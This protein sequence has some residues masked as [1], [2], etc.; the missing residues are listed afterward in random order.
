MFN[1]NISL[2]TTLV[3]FLNYIGFKDR[4]SLRKKPKQKK[5]TCYYFFLVSQFLPGTHFSGRE[6]WMGHGVAV[7]PSSTAAA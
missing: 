6:R 7:G 2:C 1:M 4:S 3:N 5:V